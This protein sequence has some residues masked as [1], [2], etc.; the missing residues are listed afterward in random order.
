MHALI[1]TWIVNL[2]QSRRDPNHQFYR[3]T[4]RFE[5]VGH[6]V[7]LTYGGVKASGRHEQGGQTIHADGREHSV[8]EAPGVVA[9]S[10]L[11][12]RA[13]HTVGKKDGVVVGR[14]TYKV[15]ADGRTMTATV[16]DLDASGKSFDQ[17]CVRSGRAHRL[18]CRVPGA[19]MRPSLSSIAGSA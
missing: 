8:P 15:S 2:E 19:E 5:V 3:A 10:T 12:P 16:S 7:S 1:E 18:E 11:E 13:L 17:D 9:I 14:A 6:S 4:M